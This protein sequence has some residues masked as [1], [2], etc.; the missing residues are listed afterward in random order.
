MKRII[1]SSSAVAIWF[2]A[3]SIAFVVYAQTPEA[4][5][6]SPDLSDVVTVNPGGTV[7]IDFGHAGNQILTWLV[8]AFGAPISI[9]LSYWMVKL[10]KK[11]GVE[12]T[13]AMRARWQAII[14]NGLNLG[15]A[16][17]AKKLEGT[18][19]GTIEIKNEAAVIAVKYVQEH[20]AETAKNLG[21]DVASE[22]AIETIKAN[23]ETMVADP[24]IATAPSISPEK[25]P[26]ITVVTPQPGGTS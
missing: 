10:A 5:L 20:G 4:P 7:T 1:L 25:P 3:V 13:E 24:K 22:K 9:A 18:G 11:A 2:L 17:A 16:E 8:G 14:L 6:P 23:I 21:L 12:A 19:A 15:A 26:V